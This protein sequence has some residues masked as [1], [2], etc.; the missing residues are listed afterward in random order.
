MSDLRI[1]PQTFT[2]HRRPTPLTNQSAVTRALV[3]VY[4]PPPRSRNPKVVHTKHLDVRCMT[5]KQ[6]V[7][8]AFNPNGATWHLTARVRHQQRHAA[9]VSH[10]RLQLQLPPESA[11]LLARP[12]LL[13]VPQPPPQ[14]ALQSTQRSHGHHNY[15]CHRTAAVHFHVQVHPPPPPPTAAHA[16]R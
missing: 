7:S 12:L 3:Q 10:R 16:Q 13:W 9:A 14:R 8:R 15:R 6:Q 2:A 4:S 11:S 5:R 1:Q